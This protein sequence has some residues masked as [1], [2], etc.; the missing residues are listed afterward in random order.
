MFST[1]A[2]GLEPATSGVTGRSWRLRADRGSAGIPGARRCFRPLRCGDSR[3]PAAVTGDLLRDERGMRRC[4]NSERD[5]IRAGAVV[6]GGDLRTQQ[7]Q[8]RWLITAMNVS[9]CGAATPTVRSRAPNRR[10]RRRRRSIGRGDSNAEPAIG[11]A[12]TRKSGSQKTTW[13][14]SAI[15]PP[16][17]L[18]GRPERFARV[19]RGAAREAASA[20]RGPR[21]AR[22]ANARRGQDVGCPRCEQA[23]SAR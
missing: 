5:E 16:L 9:R 19:C 10:D 18:S 7:S 21:A 6:V 1:G 17:R 8:W 3:V 2:T 4:L 14:P 23:W 20:A 15:S 13:K 12:P 22:P 11:S